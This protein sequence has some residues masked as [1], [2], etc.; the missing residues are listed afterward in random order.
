MLQAAPPLCTVKQHY[1]A[2]P[3]STLPGGALP[4]NTAAPPK[5]S[6]TTTHAKLRCGSTMAPQGGNT[7][8]Q[9][10]QQQVEPPETALP[11]GTGEQQHYRH[12]APLP[13]SRSAQEDMMTFCMHSRQRHRQA[14]PAAASITIRQHQCKAAKQQHQKLAAP[15]DTTQLITNSRQH[16]CQAAPQAAP[17]PSTKISRQH[18]RQAALSHQAM[19]L[20]GSATAKQRGSTT[21]S[22]QFDSTTPPFL[23]PT[24][25]LRHR[26]APGSK[27]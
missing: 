19:P 27:H 21:R 5:T 13:S 14:K 6:S 1:G 9:N 22:G 7:T 2:A 18:H 17:L 3:D 23:S 11:G 26:Q 10:H 4:G 8:R 20:P 25:R 12:A 16:H 24:A 15:P